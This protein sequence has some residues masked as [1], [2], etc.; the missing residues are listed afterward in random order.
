MRFKQLIGLMA[1]WAVFSGGFL[2]NVNGQSPT[3]SDSEKT[4]A[5]TPVTGDDSERAPDGQGSGKVT[6]RGMEFEIWPRE[7]LLR[8]GLDVPDIPKEK[9]AAWVY[10]DAINKYKELPAELAPAFDYAVSDQWPDNQPDLADYLSL[11]ENREAIELVQRAASMEQCFTPVF[12]DAGGSVVGILLPNLSHYR[13]LAKLLVVEGRRL[14]SEGNFEKAI[15]LYLTV[16]RMGEQ[17]GRGITIIEGLV[18]IAVWKVAH[19]AIIQQVLRHEASVEQLNRIESKLVERAKSIPTIDKGLDSEAR[20]GPGVVDE[21]CSRPFQLSY[22]LSAAMSYGDPG[23]LMGTGGSEADG[24]AKL[25]LRIGQLFL[26]DRTVKGHMNDYYDAIKRQAKAGRRE[27]AKDSFDEEQYVKEKVPAWDVLSRT[28][29][30]SLSRAQYLFERLR[31]DAALGRVVVAIMEFSG[32]NEGH[33]PKSLSELGDA[34]VQKSFEDPFSGQPMQYR[35]TTDGWLV[36]SF[37]LNLKDDGGRMSQKRDELDIAY[38]FPPDPL[39]PFD[40]QE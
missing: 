10:V 4:E 29:L 8:R 20:M 14:E 32:K 25:E 12:G 11:P 21:I 40:P 38:K 23:S 35:A 15:E 18:G 6:I 9:N 19:E 7:D 28:L 17:V 13:F 24:W 16:I 22:G 1:G 2:A 30:P 39:K 34:D 31:A 5:V 36:Y 3:T 27:S 33:P 26:P 37:G